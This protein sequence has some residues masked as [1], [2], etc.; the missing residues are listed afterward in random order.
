MLKILI[1]LYCFAFDFGVKN[2]PAFY[3]NFMRIS[4][5]LNLSNCLKT[6]NAVDCDCFIMSYYINF[7]DSDSFHKSQPRE[8][9]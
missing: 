9:I 8:W 5:F 4:H 3:F 6:V 2:T 7:I 1:S